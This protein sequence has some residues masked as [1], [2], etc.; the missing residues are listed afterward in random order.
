MSQFALFGTNVKKH[1]KHS[2]LN[3]KRVHMGCRNS[4]Y[5]GYGA[6]GGGRGRGQFLEEGRGRTAGVACIWV[7]P[8]AHV[9]ICY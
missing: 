8:G 2:T 9:D 7:H 6:G 1:S 4:L 5:K 3:P